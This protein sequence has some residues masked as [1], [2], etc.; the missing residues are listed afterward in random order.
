MFYFLKNL[1]HRL[2]G[3]RAEVQKALRVGVNTELR[4]RVLRSTGAIED[5]GLVSRRV[6]TDTGVA[7]LV[8]AMQN[9]TEPENFNWHGSGTGAAAEAVGNT[10]LGAEVGT[11]VAGTQSEPASNQYRTVAPLNYTTTSAITEHGIFSAI[12]T[13]T[14]LDR[15][16]FSAI[17]VVN[18]DSIQFTYT[19]TINSGG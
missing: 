9:L 17:N 16:V 5:L 8:D 6:I 13:G 18:G 14:L 7:Y 15:S 4:I 12:T 3:W 1:P 19:L 10:A 2:R 11:R